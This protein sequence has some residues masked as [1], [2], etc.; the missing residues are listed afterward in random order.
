M[1]YVILFLLWIVLGVVA[2]MLAGPIWKGKRP[3]GERGDYLVAILVS[4][5]VG[6]ADWYILPLLK[7]GGGLKFAADV[8]DAFFAALLALWVVRLVKK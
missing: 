3:I 2:A 8:G 1:T 7:I 4:V 6:L 5:A